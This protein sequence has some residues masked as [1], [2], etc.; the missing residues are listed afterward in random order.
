MGR[1]LGELRIHSASVRQHVA[2]RLFN[3]Q[4]DDQH[5]G[6]VGLAM[7]TIQVDDASPTFAS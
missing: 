6:P 5:S 7:V 4:T 1:T 3:G 2:G